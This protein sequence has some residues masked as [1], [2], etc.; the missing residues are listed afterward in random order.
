M[1]DLI[2]GLQEIVGIIN[3]VLFL[4]PLISKRVRRLLIRVALSDIIISLSTSRYNGELIDWVESLCLYYELRRKSK[5]RGVRS[6][7][8]DV[9][10]EDD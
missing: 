8:V 4:L 1:V 6:L 9:R 2:V 3:G 5:G 7:N 10:E